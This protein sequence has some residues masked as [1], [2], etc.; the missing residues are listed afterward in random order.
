[1]PMRTPSAKNSTR[2]TFLLSVARARM[3]VGAGNGI[4]ARR[5]GYGHLGRGDV[6]ARADGEEEKREERRQENEE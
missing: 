1:M 6:L 3:V 5:R 4:A 2:A